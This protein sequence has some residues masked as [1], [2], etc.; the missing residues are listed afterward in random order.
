[1]ATLKKIEVPQNDLSYTKCLI[2]Q[3]TGNQWRTQDFTMGGV[4]VPQTPRG[5]RRG[6]GGLRRGLCP[7]LKIFVLFVEN[8]IF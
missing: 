8:I 5:M 2:G 1:V 6:G 7:S 4:E 3:V